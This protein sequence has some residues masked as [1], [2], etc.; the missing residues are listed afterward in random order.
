LCQT[1]HPEVLG[2]REEGV[3]LLLGHVDLAHVHEVQHGE[4]LLV[5]DTLQVQER[6]LVGITPEDIPEEW[7]ACTED[8]FV[9]L[10]LTVVTSKGHVKEV[11][12]FSELSKSQA[13][14]CLKVIPTEAKLL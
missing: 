2:H 8:N 10:N 6:V 5:L 9:R 4:E 1:L 3:E 12:F 14:I 11:F 7:G 13:D